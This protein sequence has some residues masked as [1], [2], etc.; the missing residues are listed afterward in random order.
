M[1]AYRLRAIGCGISLA[2]MAFAGNA[3]AADP[4]AATVNGEAIASETLKPMMGTI[5]AA[6]RPTRREDIVDAEEAAR[7][8]LIRYLALAQ[9]AEKLGLDKDPSVQGTLAYY[10]IT[11]LSRAFLKEHLRRH[12][13]TEAMVQQEYEKMLDKGKLREYRL[14]HILLTQRSRAEEAI[15]KLNRGEDFSRMAKQHSIDPT[16]SA[17]GGD[18]GWTRLDAAD[19]VAFVDAVI[20][21][22]K[23]GDYTATPIEGQ[24][25]WRVLQLIEAPR[26]ASQTASFA[27]LPKQVKAKLERRA[28]Q[29]VVMNIESQIFAKAKVTRGKLTAAEALG[30][31]KVK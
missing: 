3:V 9:E 17:N 11:L 8:Q 1:D 21:L 27:E 6:S 2:A 19:D 23:A 13:V 12:P 5:L 15:A 26:N 4:A 30:D 31:A 29:R 7:E 14:R 20:K 28:S 24:S 22:K 16:A 18:I 25:G 10:R